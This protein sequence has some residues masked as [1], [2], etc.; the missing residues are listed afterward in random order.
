MGRNA[1]SKQLI[2]LAPIALIAYDIER[3]L[4]AEIS[5][6]SLG[7]T[8]EASD[9]GPRIFLYPKR[10]FEE[11]R[12]YAE[13]SP[14]G[15]L[16][17]APGNKD[18]PS[19]SIRVVVNEI[20]EDAAVIT[21]RLYEDRFKGKVFDPDNSPAEIGRFQFDASYFSTPYADNTA[22]PDGTRFAVV[23]KGCEDYDTNGR[24]CRFP[25][26]RKHRISAWF[27]VVVFKANFTTLRDR[28]DVGRLLGRTPRQSALDLF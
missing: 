8:L 18:A 19:Y 28:P 14:F 4:D 7:N 21:V 26:N 27:D 5:T 13:S 20:R 3:L 16:T 6:D 2:S 22:L 23:Y 1:S 10:S 12:D 17:K 24:L 11:K 15:F 9:I 25:L